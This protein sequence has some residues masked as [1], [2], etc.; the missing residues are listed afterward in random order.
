MLNLQ[1]FD[2]AETS[3]AILWA[4][5]LPGMLDEVDGLS[6]TSVVSSVQKGDREGFSA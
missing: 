1:L 2:N 5:E 6:T 3:Y 4:F